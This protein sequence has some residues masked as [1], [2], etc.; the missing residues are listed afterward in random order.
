[1]MSYDALAAHKRDDMGISNE[2]SARPITVALA[3]C[4]SFAAGARGPLL[5][6]FFA[7]PSLL[8]TSVVAVSLTMLC[9]LGAV[10]ARLGGTSLLRGT[11]RILAWG[12]VAMPGAQS[13]GAQSKTC[14]SQLRRCERPETNH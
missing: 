10:S 9:V 13:R 11:L 6:G 14:L 5:T 2:L 12:V 3:S 8:I 7:P 4:A 1:M